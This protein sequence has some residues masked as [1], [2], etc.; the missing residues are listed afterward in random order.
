MAGMSVV[1]LVMRDMGKGWTEA[2]LPQ[3]R[4]TQN[5]APPR[6]PQPRAAP[7]VPPAAPVPTEKPV[8]RRTEEERER[9]ERPAA[10]RPLFSSTQTPGYPGKR[11]VAVGLSDEQHDALR[12]TALASGVAEGR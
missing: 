3:G 4:I 5:G 10:L 8:A 9:H 6:P 7:T 1:A 12:T 2:D 11:F